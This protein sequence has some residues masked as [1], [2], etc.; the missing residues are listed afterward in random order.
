V[1]LTGKMCNSEEGKHMRINQ[2][3]CA[4]CLP[5]MLLCRVSCKPGRWVSWLVQ[6]LGWNE[7][8]KGYMALVIYV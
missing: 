3:D 1:A 6:T 7:K 2:S 5:K 8:K 4:L